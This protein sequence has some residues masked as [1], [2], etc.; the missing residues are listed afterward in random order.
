MHR[1]VDSAYGYAVPENISTVF[2]IYRYIK[3][4]AVQRIGIAAPR[5]KQA[6]AVVVKQRCL[7]LPDRV[8]IQAQFICAD[9]FGYNV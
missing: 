7:Y 2:Y 8:I 4:Y 3:R 9:V 6:G 5:G 1:V